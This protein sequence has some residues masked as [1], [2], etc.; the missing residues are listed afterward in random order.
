M[1]RTHAPFLLMLLLGLAGCIGTSSQ[2]ID[3]YDAAPGDRFSYKI[4]NSGGMS[5][6]R[7]WAS[8]GRSWMPICRPADCLPPRAAPRRGASTS[9]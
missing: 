4:D 9:R 8:S 1:N 6:A 7:R 2:V 3:R 5:A